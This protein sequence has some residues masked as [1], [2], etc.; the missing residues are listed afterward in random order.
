MGRKHQGKK[1]RKA[2]NTFIVG[3]AT[4]GPLRR[5]A[6]EKNQRRVVGKTEYQKN[7][8]IEKVLRGKNAILSADN[9]FLYRPWREWRVEGGRFPLIH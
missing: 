9:S 1:R 5:R 7:A 6:P 4:R 2:M 3:G 8:R